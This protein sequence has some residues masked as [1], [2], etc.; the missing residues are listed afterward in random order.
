MA[1]AIIEMDDVLFARIQQEA[2]E[3]FS[4]WVSKACRSRLLADAARDAVVWEREHPVEAARE[5]AEEAARSLE[6]EAEHEI[7]YQAEEAARRRGGD[8]AEPTAEEI[9]EA[10]WRVRA[11]FERADRRLREREEGD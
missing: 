11:L 1:T 5:R 3:N 4:E 6:S 7:Q 8:H 2:G 9:A 10:E